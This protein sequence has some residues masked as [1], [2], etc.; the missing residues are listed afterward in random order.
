MTEDV[1]YKKTLSF[2]YA[3]QTLR[4]RVSQDLFSSFD[5]DV[6][7][8]RLLRTLLHVD[9]AACRRVLDLGCGYGPIGLTLKKLDGQ[10]VVHMV[11]RDALAVD[12]SRQNAELNG[13]PDV[14]IYGSLGYDDLTAADFDLVIS[15]LPAKAGPPVLSCLLRE[16]RFCLRPGGRMAIVV[17]D[18][19]EPAVAELLADPGIQILLR[20]SW[21]GHVVFHCRF[22]GQPDDTARPKESAFQRGVY[23]RA[24]TLISFRGL[25][26]PMRTVYNLPELD[27]LDFRTELLLKGLQEIRE[28]PLRRALVFNPGQGHLPVALWKLFRPE[29]TLLADRDLLSLRCSQKNLILNGCP[30]ESIALSH[31]VG[32]LAP[33]QGP[34]D[35]VTAV[36]REE[37]GTK[38]TASTMEQAVAQAVPGGRIVVVAGSTL[39]TRLVGTLEHDERVKIRRRER[40]KGQSLLVLEVRG[41]GRC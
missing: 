2:R 3:R 41:C 31:Q 26:F 10:R 32:I 30:E 16:A 35:L 20:R 19:L 14:E 7:T 11:D 23:H 8:R 29:K 21:P 18:S 24:D 9:A 40:G 15:N 17:V 39:I 6:G 33:G 13:V 27:S 36:L 22:A 38:A 1:Y 12:Y 5:V 34:F 4:F 28:V 25:S 37:E